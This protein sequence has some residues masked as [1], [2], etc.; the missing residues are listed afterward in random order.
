M[1]GNMSDEDGAGVVLVS[2]PGVGQELVAHALE[3][4]ELSPDEVEDPEGDEPRED[5]L[6]SLHIGLSLSAVEP[7][8]HLHDRHSGPAQKWPHYRK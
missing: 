4:L 2:I 1:F 6:N 8:I 5:Q 3:G 7:E